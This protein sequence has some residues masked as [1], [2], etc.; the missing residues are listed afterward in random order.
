M[1]DRYDVIGKNGEIIQT[2]LNLGGGLME[3]VRTW[4]SKNTVEIHRT[5]TEIIK[6][7]LQEETKQK[8]KLLDAL[9]A[10]A[11][12]DALTDERFNL[13]MIAYS[14]NAKY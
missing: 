6:T 10:L 9:C 2:G 11:D 1:C 7:S 14:N 3:I 13:L 8:D 12:K 5:N 4:P